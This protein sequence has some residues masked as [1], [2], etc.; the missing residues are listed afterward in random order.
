[1]VSVLVQDSSLAF[2]GFWKAAPDIFASGAPSIRGV[3]LEL[4]EAAAVDP[5]SIRVLGPHC[6]CAGKEELGGRIWVNRKF[7][8]W[9]FPKFEK[10]FCK[11]PSYCISSHGKIMIKARKE[12]DITIKARKDYS[13]EW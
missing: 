11:I 13:S 9:R 4:R 7:A 1:M 10:K 6:Q 3:K 2:K 5:A 12:Y 8:N